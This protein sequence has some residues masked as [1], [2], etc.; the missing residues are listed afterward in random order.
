MLVDM[1]VV[2]FRILIAIINLFL[3]IAYLL[4]H[5]A[6]ATS[7]TLNSLNSTSSHP[8]N[9]NKIVELVNFPKK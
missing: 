3:A 2:S 5:Q 4:H 8:L 7:Q 6:L 9:L 1:N